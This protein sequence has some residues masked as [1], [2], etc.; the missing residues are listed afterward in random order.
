MNRKIAFKVGTCALLISVMVLSGN[1]QYVQEGRALESSSALL[2]SRYEGYTLRFKDIPNVTKYEVYDDN[3]Y[4]STRP[5]LYSADK[6]SDGYLYYTTEVVGKHNV[7]VKAYMSNSETVTSNTVEA[8]ENQPVFDYSP[9][10]PVY[11]YN[12]NDLTDTSATYSVIKDDGTVITVSQSDFNANYIYSRNGTIDFT[13]TTI[14]KYKITNLL[15]DLKAKGSNVVNLG[16]RLLDIETGSQWWWGGSFENSVCKRVMDA[17]WNIGMKC[18]VSDFSTYSNSKCDA[19][20]TVAAARMASTEFKK[21]V[22]HPAFYGIELNDEPLLTKQTDQSYSELENTCDTVKAILNT[23]HTDSFLKNYPDPFIHT[24]LASYN[25]NGDVWESLEQFQNYYKAWI[26]GTGLDYLCFDYYTY[27]TYVYGNKKIATKTYAY[28]S[29]KVIYDW[30]NQ[31]KVTY[32]NVKFHQTITRSNYVSKNDVTSQDVYGSTFLAASQG[33]F[34][35]SGYTNSRDNAKHENSCLD[36]NYDK[37]NTYT[38]AADAHKQYVKLIGLLDGY[39]FTSNS[40]TNYKY[41]Y[42]GYGDGLRTSDSTFTN[43]SGE[44]CRL[45]ANFGTVGSNSESIK[46]ASGVKYHLFGDGLTNEERTG[47]GSNVSIAQGQ[48]ILIKNDTNY[49]NGVTKTVT[50]GFTCSFIGKNPVKNEDQFCVKVAVDNNRLKNCL[51]DYDSY[52]IYLETSSKYHYFDKASC[53]FESDNSIMYVVVNLG[54]V[55]TNNRAEDTFTLK[56]AGYSSGGYS[57]SDDSNISFSVKT[58]IKALYDDP[59]T[60]GNV[61]NIYNYLYN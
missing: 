43:A 21:A 17:A 38:W 29:T 11:F 54:S 19:G 52:G 6:D 22:Q 37:T 34:G 45:V 32:P 26:D 24:D 16:N 23:W 33:N 8:V 55:I 28:D 49:L 61:T 36:L 46:V 44:T 7:Y 57:Y 25:V 15:S 40:I 12:V 18:I 13:T 1:S 60:T 27:S 9:F 4:R 20:P 42:A 48:A 2:L 5:T 14:E 51:S 31:L 59:S 47:T 56:V 35:Y 39:S 10:S 50:L 3:D 53:S 41:I 30:I 58:L